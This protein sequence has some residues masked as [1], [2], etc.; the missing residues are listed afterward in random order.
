LRDK[1]SSQYS[2]NAKPAKNI[3]AKPNNQY[4]DIV[5]KQDSMMQASNNYY[6][7]NNTTV[8]ES[9]IELVGYSE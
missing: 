9:A 7:H 1:E 8:N 5:F 2:S 4:A 3:Q 6:A